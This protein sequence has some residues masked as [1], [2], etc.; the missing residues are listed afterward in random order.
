MQ[1]IPHVHAWRL[2]NTW[3]GVVCGYACIVTLLEA[4]ELPDLLLPQLC[5]LVDGACC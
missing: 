5:C 3:S 2:N 4:S 1:N